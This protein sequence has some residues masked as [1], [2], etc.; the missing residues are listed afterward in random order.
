[1]DGRIIARRFLYGETLKDETNT[2]PEEYNTGS[3]K[4]PLEA[5]G[6]LNDRLAEDKRRSEEK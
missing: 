2:G 3:D 5:V 6:R 4:H 1:M